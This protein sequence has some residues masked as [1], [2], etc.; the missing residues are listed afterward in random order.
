MNN[1]RNKQ[2]AII[3]S[4]MSFSLKNALQKHFEL[5]EV[6]V[7]ERFDE[8]I[9]AHPDLFVFPFPN[10]ILVEKHLYDHWKK[11]GKHMFFLGNGSFET[12][13]IPLSTGEF[14]RYP[15]DCSLNFALCGP[16]LIG[17]FEHI[18]TSLEEAV[19]R[20]AWQKVTVRQGYAKCNIC[21]VSDGALI[22]EDRGI[23]AVCSKVGIDVLCLE[24]HGV[25]LQGYEYGFIGGAS[26]TVCHI[27]GKKCILFA[28]DI[29]AHPEYQRIERFC[30]DYGVRPVSLCD[31]PLIDFGSILII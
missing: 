27:D 6:P 19:A 20:Y 28:G 5:L 24:T 4:R 22:T 31:E 17:N 21:V 26:G 1:S 25:R 13:P 18:H 12:I 3:D 30:S 14:Y 9:Q 11:S 15:N 10:G 29:T 23:A 16:Y 2:T 7:N 8:P